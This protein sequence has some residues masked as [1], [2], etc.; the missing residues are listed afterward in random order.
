VHFVTWECPVVGGPLRT[1]AP[2]NLKNPASGGINLHQPAF[3][4]QIIRQAFLRGWNPSENQGLIID[5][6]LQLLADIGYP[7]KQGPC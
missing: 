5:D 6:G 1:G 3:A 4:A 7:V 2:V